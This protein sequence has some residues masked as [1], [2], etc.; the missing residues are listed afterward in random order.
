MQY[1]Q[2]M[3]RDYLVEEAEDPRINVQSILSRH[4]LL[5]GLFGNRFA[6]LQEQELRFAITMNWL[7]RLFS[8]DMCT[9]DAH[10]VL[11]ALLKGADNAAG[12]E[13][14]HFV[15]SVFAS[16]PARA[17]GLRIPNYLRQL[18]E[19]AQRQNGKP[20]NE[21]RKGIFQGLWRNLLARRRPKR[22]SVLEPACGSAN[23]YRF[24]EACGLGRLMDY[25]GFDLCEKNVRNARGLFPKARFKV[26]NAFEIEARDG[27]FDFCF[28]HDLFEHL[29]I[30]GMET[31]IAEICRVTRKEICVNFFNMSEAEEHILRPIDDYHWNTLSMSRTRELFSAS[32]ATVQVIHIGSFLRW[33]FRCDQTYNENAYTLIIRK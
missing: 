27:V 22:I 33:T 16:L 30:K 29:S 26:G 2:I 32:A 13:V 28:V 21:Q 18:L 6:D 31:A 25:T 7:L 5:E 9:D 23:D 24:M 4:F 11:H 12:M 17:D 19:E 8:K 3:L 1:D 10:A 14:P 15:S 20:V